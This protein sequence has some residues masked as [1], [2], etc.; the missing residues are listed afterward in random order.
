MAHHD[1]EMRGVGRH[2]Y[3]LQSWPMAVIWMRMLS[4]NAYTEFF[5]LFIPFF[6]YSISNDDKKRVALP[7]PYFAWNCGIFSSLPHNNDIHYVFP[8][9]LVRIHPN[10]YNCSFF[11][12]PA[13]PLNTSLNRWRTS[14]LLWKFNKKVIYKLLPHNFIRFFKFLRV[15]LA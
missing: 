4:N 7:S 3:L 12:D 15:G 13:Q 5:S 8:M 1:K 6:F 10:S 11:K 2:I 9:M 14:E